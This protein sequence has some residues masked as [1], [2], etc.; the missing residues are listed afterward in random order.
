MIPLIYRTALGRLLGGVLLLTCVAGA[1]GAESGYVRLLPNDGNNVY[2]ATGLLR[3]WPEGGQGDLA[4]AQIGIGK[5]AV[6][7]AGGRVFTEAQADG[8][9]WALCLDAATGKTLWKSMVGTNENHHQVAGP[10][11]SP[12]VDGDRVYFIP[13]NNNHGDIYAIRCP[14]FCLRASDGSTNWSEGE[15]FVS[16]EGPSPLIHGNTLYISGSTSNAMLAAVNKMTGELLWTTP[17]PNFTGQNRNP[18]GAGASPTYQVVGGVPQII[19]SIYRND[20]MGVNA[21]TGAILWH[22]QF[23][24]PASSG[25]VSTPVAVGSR[26]F[27]SGFQAPASFGIGLD[28]E[29]KDGKIEPV[30]RTQST[31]VAMQCFSHGFGGGRRGLRLLAWTT[32]EGRRAGGAA[33]RVGLGERQSAVAAGGPRLEPPEQHD[34]RRRADFCADKKRRIGDGRGEQDRLQGIRTREAGN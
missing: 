24:T 29:M 25:M 26:V 20:N 15:K 28:M 22:W 33:M 12:V 10:V 2:P 16:T 3:Q 23:P 19:I 18:Y 7:E 32:N 14:I 5:S 8:K 13:Y 30:V 21:D 27:F 9:Q 4:G 6:I 11:S 1:R 31:L 34:R 17:E